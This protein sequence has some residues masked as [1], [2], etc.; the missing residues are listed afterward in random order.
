MG[1]KRTVIGDKLIKESLDGVLLRLRGALVEKVVHWARKGN[2]VQ[3]VLLSKT[4][5]KGRAWVYER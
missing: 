2:I 1:P 5:N 4:T 3:H